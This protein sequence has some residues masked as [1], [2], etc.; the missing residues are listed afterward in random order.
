MSD[1]KPTTTEPCPACNGQGEYSFPEA[2]SCDGSDGWYKCLYCNGTGV[3]SKQ[4]PAEPEPQ[5]VPIDPDELA[6]LRRSHA[7]LAAM[8]RMLANGM[9]IQTAFRKSNRREPIHRM[10]NDMDI[11]VTD[12]FESL[13]ESI[14]AAV[15]FIEKEGRG[16]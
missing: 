1:T 7:A 2:S 3:R 15:A 8:E 5:P 13:L 11:P 14:E 9:R 12:C 4:E 16:K 6:T 10:L